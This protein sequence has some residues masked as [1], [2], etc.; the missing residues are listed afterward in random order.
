MK[1]FSKLRSDDCIALGDVLAYT[2]EY[3]KVL[4]EFNQMA[5][6]HYLSFHT[7]MPVLYSF[8]LKPLDSVLR[9]KNN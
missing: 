2:L 1:L 6:K 9:N 3:G 4:F 8:S 7:E 5:S